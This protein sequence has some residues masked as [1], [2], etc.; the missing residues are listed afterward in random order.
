MSYASI[1]LV[2][3]SVTL[4]AFAQ[5][6]FKF[7]VSSQPTAIARTVP[8]SLAI[9]FTPGVAIGLALYVIGTFLW[10]Q[11]LT[12]I[13]LSQAYPFVGIGFTLT[14]VA[15]WWLF[16]ETISPNRLIGIAVIIGGIVLLARN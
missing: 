14:T 15:G 16:A 5:V 3:V 4:S 1:S 6:A 7:G 11:A 8:G 10:L 9:L 2:L 13:D 12:K